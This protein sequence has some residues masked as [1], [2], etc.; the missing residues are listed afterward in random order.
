MFIY[1]FNLYIG[2]VIYGNNLNI[3]E[4]WVYFS[5][6]KKNAVQTGLNLLSSSQLGVSRT[7]NEEK[8]KAEVSVF[9]EILYHNFLI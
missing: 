6:T 9:S 2:S 3:V 1:S 5:L 4:I 8:P 7:T